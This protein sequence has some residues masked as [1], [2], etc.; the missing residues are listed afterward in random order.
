ME[1]QKGK[2]FFHGCSVSQ[3]VVMDGNP[4]AAFFCF[5]FILVFNLFVS[6]SNTIGAPMGNSRIYCTS[7]I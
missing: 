2:R 4:S 5:Y 1:Q 7:V 6:S 3:V